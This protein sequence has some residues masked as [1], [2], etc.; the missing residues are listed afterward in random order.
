[1]FPGGYFPKVYF[2]GNYFPPVEGFTPVSAG[3]AFEFLVG[4]GK[5]LRSPRSWFMFGPIGLSKRL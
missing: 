3:G 1:M 4:V 2:T 5:D